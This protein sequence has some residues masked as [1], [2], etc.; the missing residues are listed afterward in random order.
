MV[1]LDSIGRKIAKTR[2]A[3]GMSQE[4]LEGEAEIARHYVSKI[5]N[6]H[7]AF[8][9]LILLKIA[10]ALSVKPSAFLE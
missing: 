9:V 5:E 4:D 6:G 2:H 8:S 10:K 1:T 3:K 7:V